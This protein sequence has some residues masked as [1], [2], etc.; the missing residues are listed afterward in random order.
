MFDSP[1]LFVLC[2]I[3]PHLPVLILPL[4]LGI[5]SRLAAYLY[6]ILS[7]LGIKWG[8]VA[9]ILGDVTCNNVIITTFASRIDGAWAAI[10]G[11]RAAIRVH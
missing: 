2:R 1:L 5:A 3:I 9:K 6:T 7:L 8:A 11:G 4:G 10:G